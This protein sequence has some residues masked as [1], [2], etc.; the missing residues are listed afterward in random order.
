MTS[1]AASRDFQSPGNYVSFLL[2]NADHELAQ[3]VENYLSLGQYEAARFALLQLLDLDATKAQDLV[4]RLISLSPSTYG[5]PAT[6]ATQY[7]L[8]AL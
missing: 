1:Q 4:Y 7:E 8:I 3:L 5:L 6:L 2:S